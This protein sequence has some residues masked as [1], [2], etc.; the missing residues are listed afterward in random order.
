MQA[1]DMASDGLSHSLAEDP[2]DDGGLRVAAHAH[3]A[4]HRPFD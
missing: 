3:R 2:A 4:A 1:I